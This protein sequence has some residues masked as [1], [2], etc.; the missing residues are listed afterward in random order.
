MKDDRRLEFKKSALSSNKIDNYEYLE[1]EKI[2][3]SDE[4]RM[5]KQ[6]KFT[7]FSLEKALKKQQQ[8]QKAIEDAAEKQAKALQKLNIDQQIK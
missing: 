6:D 4:R 5:I 1:F 2:L 8:Q 7:Y 3:P